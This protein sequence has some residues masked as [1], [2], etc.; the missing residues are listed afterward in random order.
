MTSPFSILDKIEEVVL[1]LNKKYSG[2]LPSVVGVNHYACQVLDC[3]KKT[4]LEFASYELEDE[5]SNFDCIQKGSIRM[6]EIP[7]NPPLIFN[8]EKLEQR[9]GDLDCWV[10]VGEFVNTKQKSLVQ[11]W[12]TLDSTLFNFI[13]DAVVITDGDFI[14]KRINPAALSIYGLTEANSIGEEFKNVI[15][16]DYGE[17][18]REAALQLLHKNGSWKGELT[19]QTGFGTWIIAQA[20][21]KCIKN[22]QG[23]ITGYIGVYR[24]I[25]EQKDVQQ[26]YEI[27]EQR[28]KLAGKAAYDLLYEWDPKL[29]KVT[30]FGN[31]DA[32]LGFP[33][34]KISKNVEEW[35]NRIHPEDFAKMTKAVAHHKTSTEPIMYD[36]RI[37][38]ADGHY[39]NWHD[40]ALPL[41]DDEGIPIKW[42]GGCSDITEQVENNRKLAKNNE[43]L[44][45]IG[46]NFPDSYLSIVNLDLTI[47]YTNGNEFEKRGMDPNQFVGL[48][49]Q[50]VF[51]SFG[52][53][54][55]KKIKDSYTKT[56]KGEPQ[57]FELQ[58]ADQVQQY[59]TV[60][61]KN[62]E[63][64][65]EN[66]LV[67]VRNI[68]DDRQKTNLLRDSE[69]KFSKA[70]FGHPV[71]MEIID[72]KTCKRIEVNDSFI[73][74][75]GYEVETFDKR[76]ID[77]IQAKC[78]HGKT[79]L[80]MSL[81]D[82]EGV[83]KDI[84]T[85]IFTSTEEIKHVLISGAKLEVED[86]NLAILCLVDVTEQKK[87]EESSKA[88]QSRLKT[89]IETLPDL[90]WLKDPDG[91]YLGCN[92]RFSELYNTPEEEIIGKTDKDFVAE[93]VADFFR[94]HDLNAIR[95]GTSQMNEEVL[96]FQSDGHVEHVE[97]IKAPVYT[98]EGKLL[99][100][101]GIARD[102]TERIHQ[103]ETLER[104]NKLLKNIV[105]N[106]SHRVRAPLTNI[107]GLISIL[108][109]AT[110][111]DLEEKKIIH[112]ALIK[113][114]D[115]LDN[116]IR[117]IVRKTEEYMWESKEKN[118][119]VEQGISSGSA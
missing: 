38:H 71:A 21:V 89:L 49:I 91:I 2:L 63:G 36:Y 94:Q 6:F 76:S 57:I 78:L 80:L 65:I 107:M 41:L 25:T 18:E 119:S 68:T 113:S 109:T 100:V 118:P 26:A 86:E 10:L 46:K 60:P 75:M 88:Y 66:I 98:D 110:E 72:Y 48:H 64:D 103:M 8:F 70:F 13:P 73:S 3:T 51:A 35:L 31:I 47:G 62:K 96:T 29:N 16:I 45:L 90:V 67:V 5:Q 95:A 108:E 84:S 43:L 32:L 106:Q 7:N 27:S 92:K 101:L 116:I 28:L 40:H 102:I 4:F 9:F 23:N 59:S 19:Q 79:D 69:E 12:E 20:S 61:I 85:E 53:D 37:Q 77:D 55:V 97:T 52:E 58:I 87:A 42:V 114:A 104:Q 112:S 15:P 50:E 74:M 54:V 14:V 11:S 30:W 82:D 24:D 56:F 115:E 99:G 39:L 81:L 83:V 1:V 105:W 111:I 17:G 22:S 34:G 44:S 93:E 117:E 33:E